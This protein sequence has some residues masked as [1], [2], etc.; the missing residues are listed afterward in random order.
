MI[1]QVS[2]IQ[3][4]RDVDFYD[5]FEMNITEKDCKKKERGDSTEK[6]RA[7]WDY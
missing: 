6:V 2:E 7:F 1:I 3:F 5:I 4:L